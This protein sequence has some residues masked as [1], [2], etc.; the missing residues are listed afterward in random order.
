MRSSKKSS[1]VLLL[2]KNVAITIGKFYLILYK[3]ATTKCFVTVCKPYG[4][5]Y[6][7]FTQMNGGRI[8]WLRWSEERDAQIPASNQGQDRR[9]RRR[10]LASANLFS[11]NRPNRAFCAG[12]MIIKMLPKRKKRPKLLPKGQ[13][14]HSNT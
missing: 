3:Q 7:Y 4:R 2:N 1:F 11:F 5:C 14:V 6:F 12:G 10:R 13:K 9:R 8:L